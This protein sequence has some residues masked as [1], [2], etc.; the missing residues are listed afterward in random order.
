MMN[1]K[2]FLDELAFLLQDIED[3]ERDEAIQYYQDYFDE[4]G[5]EN[6]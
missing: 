2:E 3:V 4:A 1:R 6:E 5:I